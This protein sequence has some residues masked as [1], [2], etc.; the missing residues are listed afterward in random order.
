MTLHD[1]FLE[2]TELMGEFHRIPTSP[3][4][5][6]GSKLFW[7]QTSIMFVYIFCVYVYILCHVVSKFRTQERHETRFVPKNTPCSMQSLGV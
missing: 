7:N 3:K 4:D 5:N 2:N 1:L 6:E